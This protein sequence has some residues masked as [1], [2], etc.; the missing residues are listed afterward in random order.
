MNNQKDNNRL[1]F[2]HADG[3]DKNFVQLCHGLDDFLNIILLVEKKTAHSISLII[4][5]GKL[6]FNFALMIIR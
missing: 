4:H 6:L 3:R 2:K 1:H 5:G